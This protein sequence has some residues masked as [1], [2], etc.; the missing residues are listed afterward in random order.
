MPTLLDGLYR[1]GC[2]RY[3]TSNLAF[4]QIPVAPEVTEHKMHDGGVAVAVVWRGVARYLLEFRPKG[5]HCLLL[6]VQPAYRGKGILTRLM[7]FMEPWWASLGIEHH[8]LTVQP[9]SAG[10]ASLALCGFYEYEPGQW[11]TPIPAPR[12]KE[13]LAWVEGGSKA[14]AEPAWRKSLK[15]G[16]T[17][18]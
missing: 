12:A 13:F 10:E 5:V 4:P 16:P 9:G 2:T 17:V 1:P 8:T 18:F 7:A 14:A 15:E 3:L 6:E 11:G